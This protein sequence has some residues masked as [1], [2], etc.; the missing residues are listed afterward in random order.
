MRMSSVPRSIAEAAGSEFKQTHSD[1]AFTSNAA[2][3]YLKSLQSADWERMKPQSAAMSGDDY[4]KV[5]SKL[6][7]LEA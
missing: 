4:K 2:N 5:W 7:G 1:D 6:S 3:A